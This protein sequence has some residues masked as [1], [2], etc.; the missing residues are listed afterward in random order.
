[1]G[2]VVIRAEALVASPHTENT[3]GTNKQRG[4]IGNRGGKNQQRATGLIEL[5]VSKG[6][7]RP[8]TKSPPVGSRDEGASGFLKGEFGSG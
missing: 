4:G 3:G 2:V 6:I 5:C 8:G 1:M 7:A